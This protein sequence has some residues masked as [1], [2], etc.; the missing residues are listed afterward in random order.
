MFALGGGLGITM[1]PITSSP[2]ASSSDSMT[3]LVPEGI[4]TGRNLRKLYTYARRNKIVIPVFSIQ[5]SLSCNAVLYAARSRHSPIV[6]RVSHAT[7]RAYGSIPKYSEPFVCDK[8]MALAGALSLGQHVR[9]MS[10]QYGVRVI[11]QTETCCSDQL[12]KWFET[13]LEYNEAHYLKSG[14]PLFSS[15]LLDLCMESDEQEIIAIAEK[16][17]ERLDQSSIWLDIRLPETPK[18]CAELQPANPIGGSVRYRQQRALMPSP[19]RVLTAYQSLSRVGAINAGFSLFIVGSSEAI[20]CERFDEYRELLRRNGD[21]QYWKKIK[22]IYGNDDDFCL[23]LDGSLSMAAKQVT[24]TAVESQIV[25]DFERVID[26]FRVIG[27]CP[28]H[29]IYPANSNGRLETSN[30][31]PKL[32]VSKESNRQ[33]KIKCGF[34]TYF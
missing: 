27:Q 7:A 14:E 33:R 29:R 23:V 25:N 26:E 32:H 16:Y 24:G 1:K 5:D 4:V 22:Q 20:I 30:L 13:L 28:S 2:A 18:L 31:D 6:I 21:G 17:L 3:Y 19:S 9:T 15:H 12:A 10:K 34:Q 8:D 11:L